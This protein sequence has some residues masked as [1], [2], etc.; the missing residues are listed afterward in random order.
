MRSGVQQ[1][2]DPRYVKRKIMR[3]HFDLILCL[4]LLAVPARGQTG[5]LAQ[6]QKQKPPLREFQI[7]H[8]R[9]I[10]LANGMVIFLYEDHELPLI[11]GFTVIRGGAK[12][13]PQEK[14]GLVNVYSKAWRL[15][16]TRT[17]T[18]D[19]IDDFLESHG[20]NIETF[21]DT[22][23]TA[24][25][26]RSL[27]GNFDDT[28]E[29]ILDL[30]RAPQFQEEQIQLAKDQVTAEVLRQ[31][32]NASD[33]IEHESRKLVY[34]PQSPYARVPEPFAIRAI[35]REDLLNWHKAFV[36][37]NNIILSLLGDFNAK[38][39]EGRLRH[40]FASW[41]QGTVIKQRPIAIS[42]SIPG[43]YL[44]SKPDITQSFVRI[45]ALGA[46]R[47][48]SDYYA[49]EVF[50]QIFGSGSSSKLASNIR[51]ARGLAYQ[52]GGAIGTDFDHAGM[53]QI[54]FATKSAT[55]IAAIEAVYAEI[56]ALGKN[57]LTQ[58]EIRKAQ[59]A[60]LNAFIFR[61]SSKE[62]LLREQMAYEFYGYPPDFL[63]HYRQR[64]E[65]VTMQDVGRVI[66][67]YLR[68]ERLSMLVV[69]KPSDFERPLATLGAVTAVELPRH[70][71]H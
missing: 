11:R 55:T 40:A 23:L 50:N 61:I 15:G 66:D 10:A 32:E 35:T 52:I 1:T 44:I 12:D 25:T 59:Q 26:W 17:K 34:G 37:P 16:G 9:R 46:T 64:I 38:E 18:G 67:S 56:D 6:I 57:G 63:D 28:F 2:P 43:I 48:N 7:P 20:A 62:R 71:Q 33:I 53:L 14:A 31:N 47:K 3:I 4:L 54:S 30:L 49:I 21:A 29:I 51:T 5:E 22:D 58:A 27:K 24:I 45:V 42:T 41:P 65:K 69:G 19:Q 13:E 8:P 60:I 39:M 70:G 68:K 36:Q